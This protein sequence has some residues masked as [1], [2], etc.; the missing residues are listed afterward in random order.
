MIIPAIANLLVIIH[1]FH[2][3]RP[4]RALWPFKANP[5]LVVD[6]DAVLA[7]AIT[8]ETFKSVSG[9]IKGPNTVRR[10]KPFEPQQGLPLKTLKRL[11]PFALEKRPCLLIPKTYDH[12]LYVIRQP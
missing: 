12:R 7:L 5:H 6:A 4:R 3:K 11:N 2:I 1:N 8:L 9:G 10:V